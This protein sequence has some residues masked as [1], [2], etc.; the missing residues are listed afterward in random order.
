MVLWSRQSKPEGLEHVPEVAVP[1]QT[2]A[3][4][5][6]VKKSGKGS[7][8]RGCEDVHDMLRIKKKKSLL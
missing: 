3:L 5:N 2:S 1:K 4:C 6:Q 7:E 8:L